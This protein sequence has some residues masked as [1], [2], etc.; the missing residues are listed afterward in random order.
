MH[1][2]NVHYYERKYY[3]G[4]TDIRALRQRKKDK[5]DNSI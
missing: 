1:L 3:L 4:K 5:L 2:S